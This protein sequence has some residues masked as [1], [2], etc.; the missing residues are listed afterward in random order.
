MLVEIF[1]HMS[2]QNML[3]YLDVDVLCVPVY[4]F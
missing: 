1:V 3:I 2:L 4:I